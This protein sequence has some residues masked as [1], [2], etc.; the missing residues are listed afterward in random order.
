MDALTLRTFQFL[1]TH[2]DPAIHEIFASNAQRFPH[3]PCV[4]ETNSGST[5]QR[6]FT[7]RQINEG[8]NQLAHHLLAYG[9]EVGDVVM[10][11]AYRGFVLPLLTLPPPSTLPFSHASKSLG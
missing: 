7:Y 9:C 2:S 10:I 8:S 3:R 5:P 6:L 4:I 1:L 11:Y